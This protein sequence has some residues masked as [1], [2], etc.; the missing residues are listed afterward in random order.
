MTAPSIIDPTEF[1]HEQ[2]SQ[3]SPDL[4]R[5][6]LTTFI[7]TLMSADADSVCGASWGERSE[8]RTNTRNGYRHRDFDTRAGT[9]DV[10]IPKLRNGSYFPDWLLERRRRAERALTTVV[11][12]CYLLG[13]STRRMEK[14]VE[15]L[16]ITRLSKSQVSVMAQDLDAQVADFRS[17]PLDQGP[18]T[19]V[20][21]DALVLKVR[22]GGRVVNVHALLATGVNADGHREIL[23][24]QV[25][26]AEDGAGWLGFF[27]DLTARGL[28]GVR[29]VTSDAHAGLVAAIGATLP[30]ATWQRCRTHY[31]ANL[32]AATPKSSWPWV[33]AL[34]HSVYDQPDAASV[35]AQFDRVLDAVAEKLPKVAEHLDT[36]RADVLAFTSFPK[37]LW[38]QIWS[39]NPSERLNREIRRRTDVVGIFPD[40]DSLIRLVGAVL[41]EQHDEWAEGRRYLGLDVLARARIT[42]V[43]DHTTDTEE[44]TST[45]TIPALSA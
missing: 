17:R 10:A 41:A 12:T 14:L 16:G 43:P 19:F 36:A 22:E 15:S 7:N 13:V 42:A 35:H 45:D 24:L 26:S 37:E 34:L 8:Q 5:Q 6:M 30:G 32:M 28:S 25:T 2:L 18:Y 31:A 1:L 29:L 9:I 33:R 27:R 44:V 21:A 39:N 20:A 11:A 40:R 4:L 38:R 23:G 3:A